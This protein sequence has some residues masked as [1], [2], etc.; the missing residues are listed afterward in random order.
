[1]CHHTSDTINY[2]GCAQTIQLMMPPKTRGYKTFAHPKLRCSRY[3]RRIRYKQR[4]HRSQTLYR[5]CMLLL[6]VLAKLY[7]YSVVEGTWH[8]LTNQTHSSHTTTLTRY[9]RAP[10]EILT[11]NRK[12]TGRQSTKRARSK[13]VLHLMRQ[14]TV[15]NMAGA[16]V[17]G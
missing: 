1:M 12:C 8:R 9:S 2:A 17:A 13:A 15:H 10:T 7:S 5:L 14:L 6:C 3:W 4:K 11:T 16:K